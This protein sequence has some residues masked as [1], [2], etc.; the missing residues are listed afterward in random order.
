M[1]HFIISTLLFFA[2]QGCDTLTGPEEVQCDK[3]Y[4]DFNEE[5]CIVQHPCISTIYYTSIQACEDVQEA[6]GWSCD[7]ECT[8]VN[9]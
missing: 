5:E 4:P 3:H 7:E 8:F 2:F 1:R 6:N 9:N